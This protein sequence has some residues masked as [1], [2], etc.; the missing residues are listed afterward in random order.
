MPKILGVDPGVAKCGWAIV[1]PHKV[2]DF[3]IFS[4][5]SSQ[6]AFNDKLNEELILSV[7]F[8]REKLKEVDA[9]AWEIVPSFGAMSQRDR[10][11]GVATALKFVTWEMG[12]PWVGRVPMSIKKMAT[13]SGKA[14]KD[15]M[16]AVALQR[17]PD[18]A[19]DGKLPAD[20]FDAVMIADVARRKGEW[21]HERF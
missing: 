14:T 13:G 5:G 20:V 16:K 19:K 17:F 11:V 9:V 12:L 1:E 3:G 6:K 21:S 4:P 7:K 18:L 2:V 15:D 8:F 10:V